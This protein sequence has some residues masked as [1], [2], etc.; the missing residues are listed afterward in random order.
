M[1]VDGTTR[2]CSD[3]DEQ[4]Q[5]DVKARDLSLFEKVFVVSGRESMLAEW[6]VVKKRQFNERN[7]L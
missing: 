5:K 3:V 1:V 7:K 6:H 2:G 4:W